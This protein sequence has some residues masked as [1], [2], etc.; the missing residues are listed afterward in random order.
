[1]YFE[2]RREVKNLME[3]KTIRI[4]KDS[5]ESRTMQ[6]PFIEKPGKGYSGA[7][8]GSDLG[9]LYDKRKIKRQKTAQNDTGY[10]YLFSVSFFLRRRGHSGRLRKRLR[11]ASAF[12]P[13]FFR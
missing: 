9:Y 12:F 11:E 1:M 7:G 2:K 8:Y 6:E 13:A 5:E 10:R 3:Q 4:K